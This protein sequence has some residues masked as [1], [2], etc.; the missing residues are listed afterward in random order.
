MLRPAILLLFGF[1][2]CMAS[3]ENDVESPPKNYASK[4]AEAL[5]YC[6]EKNF[7]E[8]YYFLVDLSIHSGRKRF[9]IYSFKQIIY[10]DYWIHLMIIIPNTKRQNS[11]TV[12][13]AIAHPLAN[14]K[15]ANV[16]TVPGVST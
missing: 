7:S 2:S 8:D 1:I 4:H 15:L 11:A 6:K 10:I 3:S 13:T 12:T 16:I 14:I 5:A 9:Y